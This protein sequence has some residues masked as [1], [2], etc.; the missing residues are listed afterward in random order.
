MYW[1]E[2][3]TRFSAGRSTPAMRAIPLSPVLR[4]RALG[5]ALALLVAGVGGADDPHDALALHDLALVADLLHRRADLHD[6][7]T[8]P[9]GSGTR[10]KAPP[11]L[12]A[13]PSE[14]H[15]HPLEFPRLLTH[16]DHTH[17][18]DAKGAL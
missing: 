1:S 3:S 10:R 12:P 11:C 17:R 6:L 15:P 18:P 14:A 8:R 4:A 13:G 7:V 16:P 9:K 5:L 2:I